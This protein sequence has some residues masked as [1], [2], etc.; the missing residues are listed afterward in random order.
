MVTSITAETCGDRSSCR[1]D[2]EVR[3]G[4]VEGSRREV[5]SSA[6]IFSMSPRSSGRIA[7]VLVVAMSS[8]PLSTC[9]ELAELH[10][11][12][13]DFIV[14]FVVVVGKKFEAHRRTGR[15]CCRG[16]R[17]RLY[18]MCVKR[19][20]AFERYRRYDEEYDER[21]ERTSD[22]GN[23]NRWRSCSSGKAMLARDQGD[24]CLV[25]FIGPLKSDL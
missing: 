12:T 14:S 5:Q 21:I 7:T 19:D 11:Q 23:P 18:E 10:R 25:L 2:D 20:Q 17:Q 24:A 22:E 3:A 16:R 4:A 6:D 13:D 1:W 9:P 15:F 8:S